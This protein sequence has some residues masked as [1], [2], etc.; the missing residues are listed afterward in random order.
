MKRA[1]PA[2]CADQGWRGFSKDAGRAHYEARGFRVFDADEGWLVLR[3]GVLEA[4][5]R[6]DNALGWVGTVVQ[7]APAFLLPH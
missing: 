3:K 2:R 6:R 7:L 5:V 1:F 4:Y